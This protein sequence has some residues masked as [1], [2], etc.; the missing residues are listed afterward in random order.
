MA[1]EPVGMGG[2]TRSSKGYVSQ[3]SPSLQVFGSK[4]YSNEGLGD[5]TKRCGH[6]GQPLLP[7]QLFSFPW[8]MLVFPQCLFSSL[9]KATELSKAGMST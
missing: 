1:D 4:N 7:L 5:L 8:Q 6:L 2:L 3:L 9:S